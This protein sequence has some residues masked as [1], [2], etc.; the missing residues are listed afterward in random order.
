MTKS[1]NM[2]GVISADFIY[3]YEINFFA[4]YNGQC[5]IGLKGD[6]E[7]KKLN[8]QHQSFNLRT[9]QKSDDAG[10]FFEISGSVKLKP[11]GLE[12]NS[13]YLNSYIIIRYQLTDNSYIVIGTD[14]YPLSY[15]MEMLTPSKPAG[16]RGYQLSFSG[17][18][19]IN[20][21]FLDL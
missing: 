5:R 13:L 19:L 1:D 4:A 7:W 15:T 9:P 10:F 6:A 14:C 20:P 2:G 16:F 12:I 21:P 8:I 18:Q 17:K 3:P 11:S